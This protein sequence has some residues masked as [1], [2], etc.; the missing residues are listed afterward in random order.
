MMSIAY[1]KIAFV[2][3]SKAMVNVNVNS[4]YR[5]YENVK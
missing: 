3:K 4:L 2:Y 1:P 5:F